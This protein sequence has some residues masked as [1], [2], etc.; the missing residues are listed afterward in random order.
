MKN[1]KLFLILFCTVV[2]ASVGVVSCE[3]SAANV[4][5]VEADYDVEEFDTEDA[6]VNLDER[7]SI[8]CTFTNKGIMKHQNK[9][10]AACGEPG[11]F[12]NVSLSPEKR[13][14]TF[15]GAFDTT[16][17]VTATYKA[18]NIPVS[19]VSKS[20]SEVIVAIAGVGLLK[21]GN[22]KFNV[23]GKLKTVP[24][25]TYWPSFGEEAGITEPDEAYFP[26]AMWQCAA[27]WERTAPEYNYQVVTPISASYSPTKGQLLQ[28]TS[29]LEETQLA[30]VM[31][32]AT[33]AD[34]KGFKKVYIWERNR[35][36]N[37]SLEKKRYTFKDGVFTTR[38]GEAA[39]T[40]FR[41]KNIL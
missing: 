39:F 5:A 38:I 18:T 32:D 7:A 16:K 22:L 31:E 2:F 6:D 33:A 40:H 29:N 15:S 26:S 4:E 23:C 28:R 35:K 21:T 12:G 25:S 34:A 3:K 13:R 11:L 36:G 27:Q 14:I 41:P 20:A 37:G 9:F 24:F 8:T 17:G 1:L 19:I 30:I 10:A